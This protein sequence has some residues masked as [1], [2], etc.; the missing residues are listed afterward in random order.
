MPKLI[1]G[2]TVHFVTSEREGARHC[3]AIVS[4]VRDEARGLV[5]L[6]VFTAAGQT[7]AVEN[8]EYS[9]EPRPRTW[10]WVEGTP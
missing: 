5:N 10:H 2:R 7:Y 4:S 8:V 9:D 3:A 1:E 6:A